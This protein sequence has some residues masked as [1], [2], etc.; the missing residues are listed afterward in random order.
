MKVKETRKTVAES[1]PPTL[2]ELDDAER[3]A[4]CRYVVYDVVE[5]DPVSVIPSREL[6]EAHGPIY[7]QTRKGNKAALCLDKRYTWV[8]SYIG[9]PGDTKAFI[10]TGY[11]LTNP[12]PPLLGST[13]WLGYDKSNLLSLAEVDKEHL[14]IPAPY[15]RSFLNILILLGSMPVFMIGPIGLP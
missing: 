3:K 10:H 2:E 12:L 15:R 5:A 11:V 14:I 7:T 8:R 9:I 6:P 1:F 13:L 4:S